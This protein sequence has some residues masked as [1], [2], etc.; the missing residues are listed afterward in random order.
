VV[1]AAKTETT[2]PTSSPTPDTAA[3]P[4]PPKPDAVSSPPPETSVTPPAPETPVTPPQPGGEIEYLRQN[5]KQVIEQAPED[6]KRTPAMAILR[7]A[8]VKPVVFEDDNLVLAFRYPLHKEN[9]EKPQNQE[10]AEKIISSFLGRPCHIR[11]VHKPEDNHLVEAALK[12]GAQ[13]TSVEEK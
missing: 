7:S 9:L 6:T 13:I 10:I 2:K 8:G 5:W 4:P 1:K 11:C 3:A 12:M